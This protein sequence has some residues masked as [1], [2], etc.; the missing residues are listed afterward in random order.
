VQDALAGELAL[1]QIEGETGLGKTRLLDELVERLGQAR[2]GRVSCSDL[3]R[4]LPYVPLAAVLR[5]AI[6][7]VTAAASH[8]PAMAEILPELA[9]DSRRG[10]FEDLDVLEA[11]VA[12][13]TENAPLALILDDVERADHQT[14]AALAYLRRRAGR[15]GGALVTTRA[16]EA[17]RDIFPLLVPDTLVRLEPLSPGDLAP[18]GIPELHEATGGNPRFVVEAVGRG[19]PVVPSSTLADALIAQCRAEGPRAY[20]MLAA[21][22][23]LDQPFDPEQLAEI[24]EADPFGLTEE[25]ER[26][27]ERRLLRVDGL[28]FRFRYD[29]VRQVLLESVSPARRRLVEQRVAAG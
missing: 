28:G 24:L 4:H 17:R 13:V 25:L 21:A 22:A 18:L 11:L 8:L 7:D 14:L 3:E 20:R 23:V 12:L 10:R 29:L 9:S 2:I 6:A 1:I 27:C 19:A 15:V 5:A 16:A 26:L